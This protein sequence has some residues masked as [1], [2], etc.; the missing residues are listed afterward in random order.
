MS[1]INKKGSKILL[2]LLKI[3]HFLSFFHLLFLNIK[4]YCLIYQV[5]LHCGMFDMYII[6]IKKKKEVSLI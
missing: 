3:Y 1:F 2:L 4:F 6:L 5:F